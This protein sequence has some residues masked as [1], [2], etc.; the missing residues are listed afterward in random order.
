MTW[1]KNGFARSHLASLF[2]ISK[3]TVTRYLITWIN[4]CYFSVG[5]IP[6]WPSREVIDST[7]PQSFK[8]TYRYARCII[9]CTELFCQRPSS[10]ST[11]SC[12]Y[13]H[14]KSHVTYQELL[15]IVPSGGIT[16]ISQLYDGS[17]SDKEIARRSGILDERPWQLNGIVMADRGFTIHEE[18][19]QLKVN[20]S[21][22]AFLG[23]RSQLTK[24]EVKASQ[25]ITLVRIHVA[26]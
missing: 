24:A 4:F 25:T 13:S 19:K 22:P 16:F 21:I 1:L 7:I 15:G 5:A 8:N 11:Q 23:G 14:Y 20:L 18:L 6:I 12:M 9:N 26:A 3:S 10:L 2:K 17:I